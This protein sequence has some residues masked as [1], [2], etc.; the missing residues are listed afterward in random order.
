[1][2]ILILILLNLV[3]YRRTLGYAGIC[4]DIPVF[5]GGVPI[6]KG[7]KWMY[8]WYHLYGRKYT[9]WKLAHAQTLGMHTLTCILIYLAF[10]K[11][12][13]SFIASLLFLINPVNNAGSCWISGRTYV[14]NTICA[15]LMW[16][17][18]LF[19]PITYLYGTYFSGASLILFP[20]IF[21]FTKYKVL[22]LLVIVGFLR[23]HSRIF[24]KKNP[25]S[26]FNTESNDELK[27]IAPRKI[28]V[29]LKTFG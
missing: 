8:F 29:S 7:S 1:M 21:L 13:V 4:D 12:Y 18:P 9:S 14:Q 2:L 28:I 16:M 15:L 11:N 6:P 23:E 25:A 27:K 22:A 24:D 26:K 19:A 17:F 10:G 3:F 5:N 20:L